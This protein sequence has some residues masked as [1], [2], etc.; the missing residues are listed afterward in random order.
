M[1]LQPAIDLIKSLEGFRS[2]PYQDIKGIWTIGYGTTKDID[3]DSDPITE[4]EAEDL[5]KADLQSAARA[6]TNSVTVPLTDNQFGALCSFT[7]NVG[8]GAFEGSTLL[9]LINE[10]NL[11][12][13]G[14]QFLL[15]NKVRIN[16]IL[17]ESEGLS[18]RR[19]IERQLFLK[20]E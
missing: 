5:L 3:E 12:K 10:N 16:G 4:E 11:S 6:I 8:I 17:K 2:E 18:N 20:G 7:Y 14:D 19:I 13:A 9:K 1:N 15:W